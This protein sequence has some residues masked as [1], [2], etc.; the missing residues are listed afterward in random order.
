MVKVMV[1]AK[2]DPI[3]NATARFDSSLPEVFFGASDTHS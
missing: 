1:F 3:S 2:V